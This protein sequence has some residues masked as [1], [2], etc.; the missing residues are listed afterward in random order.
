MSEEKN[1]AAGA[2][3]AYAIFY[4]EGTIAAYD[5]SLVRTVI[6]KDSTASN[7]AVRAGNYV[8][9]PC[10]YTDAVVAFDLFLTKTL[11]DGIGVS[12][13]DRKFA[14]TTVNDLAAIGGE[15]TTLYMYDS[16]LVRTTANIF[17]SPR[18]YLS[19]TTI[20]NYAIFG[21]GGSRSSNNTTAGVNI[22]QYV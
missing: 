9:F 18:P 16:F 22:Y 15:N 4:G 7:P 12:L 8:L 17:K 19:A 14:A 13:S 6:A 1:P 20:G 10:K 5:K 2:N 3:S 21:G 11:V